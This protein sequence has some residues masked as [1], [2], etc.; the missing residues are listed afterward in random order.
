MSYKTVGTFLNGVIDGK[1][2]SKHVE[3]MSPAASKLA[4][5]F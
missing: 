4:G 2:L 3:S 5:G 1:R